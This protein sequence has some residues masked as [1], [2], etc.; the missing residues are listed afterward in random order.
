MATKTVLLNLEKGQ[1]ITWLVSTQTASH[2]HAVIRDDSTTSYCNFSTSAAGYK[3]TTGHAQING[4]NLRL[5]IEITE[6]TTILMAEST[7]ELVTT[8]GGEV[9]GYTRAYG[10][11]DSTDYDFNDV[12]VSIITCKKVEQ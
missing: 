6:A 3:S 5:E 11:E 4:D 12:M 1:A 10:F 7:G 2:V 9:I 8:P